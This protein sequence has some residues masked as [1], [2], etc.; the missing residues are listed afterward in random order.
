MYN[1]SYQFVSRFYIF[2]NIIGMI[3]AFYMQIKTC[4]LDCIRFTFKSIPTL[5]VTFANLHIHRSINCFSSFSNVAFLLSTYIHCLS[6]TKINKKWNDNSFNS[7]FDALISNLLC[8]FLFSQS[9]SDTFLCFRVTH[10][11]ASQLDLTSIH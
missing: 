5:T 7:N 3:F 11:S 2:S 4:A 9:E 10:I 6:I 1:L 8:L